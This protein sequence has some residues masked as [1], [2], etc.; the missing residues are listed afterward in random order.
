LP[1]QQQGLTDQKGKESLGLALYKSVSLHTLTPG[2][3]LAKEIQKG[4]FI[5][6]KD[7]HEEKKKN[8]KRKRPGNYR[9]KTHKVG[10]RGAE[11][12]TVREGTVHQKTEKKTDKSD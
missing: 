5:N 11:K 9:E 3:R 10:A 6:Q 4:L 2:I 7:R 8:R 12:C 1:G